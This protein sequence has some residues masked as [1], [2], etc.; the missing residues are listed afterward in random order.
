M[1]V[2]EAILLGVLQGVTEFLPISSSGH[3]VLGKVILG[4]HAEGVAFEVAVHLGTFFAVLT[5]LWED[6]LGVLKACWGAIRHPSCRHWLALYQKDHCFQ[7]GVL[8]LLASL[9]AGIVG[10]LFK[11]ELEGT[12]SAPI[13]VSVALLVTGTILL[14]TRWRIEANSRVSMVRALLIGIAQ[15][16]AILPGI[17]RSGAT[18]ATGIYCGVGREEAAR[19]SFLMFV[20]AVFGAVALEGWGLI[21]KGSAVDGWVPLVVG[22][23]VAYAAGALALRWLFGVIRRGRLDRFAYYCYTVGLIGLAACLW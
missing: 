5:L 2:I 8:I 13:F 1:T 14:G 15:A 21:Q 3:L 19:F 22:V 10:C 12:F 16:L 18:V 7:L 17:S 23:I 6:C 20:P 11:K 9:P 4:V